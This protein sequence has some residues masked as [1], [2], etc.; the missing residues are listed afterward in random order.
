MTPLAQRGAALMGGV[1]RH[2]APV[3]GG[4]LSQVLRIH[5]DD[6]RVAIVKHGPLAQAEASMLRT[7]HEAGVPAPA[8]LGADSQTLVIECLPTDGSLDNAWSDVGAQLAVLH[9]TTGPGYGWPNAYAFDSVSIDNARTE[10]WPEFWAQRRLLPHLSKLPVS[11]GRRLERLA[12]DL[13]NRLPQQPAA[14][15]LHGDLWGGNVL[16][17]GTRLSGLIDP[18]CYYGH[19]EVD[20]AMLQL[21]DQPSPEFFEAYA[22]LQ[23]GCAERLT[24][25]RLWPAL[26]HLLLFGGGYHA[27]VGRNL[28]AA[29][30]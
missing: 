1:L 6:G 3:S 17:T 16:V 4:G 10:C 12:A 13:P 7:I 18:A 8:V 24:I 22:P 5:L 27:M 23:A 21:F 26:V 2:A 15:L 28:S 30:V 29:G 11:L 14:S 20:I 19:S 25:Y 9:A